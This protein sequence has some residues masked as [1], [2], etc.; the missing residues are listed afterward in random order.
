MTGFTTQEL[1]YLRDLLLYEQDSQEGS[2]H[3]T[4]NEPEAQPCIDKV[5]AEL[6]QRP[7]SERRYGLLNRESKT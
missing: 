5:N 6:Q 4:P 1:E 7:A 3:L 2:K